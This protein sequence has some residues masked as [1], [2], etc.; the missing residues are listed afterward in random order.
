MPTDTHATPTL[1]SHNLCPYVQRAVIALEEL[2][3][4]YQRIDVDLENPPDWFKRISPLGKVPLLLL[5]GERVLFESAVIAEYVNEIGGGGLLSKS[6]LERA[7]ERAWIEFASATLDRI[8]AL[9]SASDEK[10]FARIAAELDGKWC[11]LEE[12]LASGQFFNG[13]T[14]SLV[15]AAFAPVFRYID[16]FEQLLERKLL[17]S[18]P[19]I[20]QWRSALA[21][22]DS[23]IRAAHPDYPTLLLIFLGKRDSEL[24]RRARLALAKQHAA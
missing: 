11:Q 9:Y 6:P 15:D 2:S 8:G 23:V 16:L 17:D 24:G 19:R 22:R 5:E 3:I 10:S 7:R 13:D 21:Q 14:F 12:V 4:D 20:G 1:I 18:F